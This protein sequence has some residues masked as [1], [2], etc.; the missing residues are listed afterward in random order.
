MTSFQ[1]A[2]IV[3]ELLTAIDK[4]DYLLSTIEGWTTIASQ[5]L[6]KVDATIDTTGSETINANDEA[7]RQANKVVEELKKAETATL[8][9]HIFSL[10]RS[11]REIEGALVDNEAAWLNSYLGRLRQFSAAYEAFFK[12]YRFGDLVRL[13]RVTMTVRDWVESGRVH[14]RLIRDNIA[15]AAAHAGP[16]EGTLTLFFESEFLVSDLAAKLSAIYRI[17]SELCQYLSVAEYQHP[18]R[19]AKI[20]SGS[21]WVSLIG[22]AVVVGLMK[23]LIERTLGYLYRNLTSEGQLKA[24]PKKLDLVEQVLQSAAK[25]EEAGAD[26]D[27][28]RE[29]AQRSAVKISED[30]VTLLGGEP[31]VTVDGMVH[32]FTS[33]LHERLLAARRPKLIEHDGKKGVPETGSPA[34][35]GGP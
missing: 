3:E 19:A 25:L 29:N 17:Y 1:L 32:S 11:L 23:S 33:A 7:R 8:F 27:A 22:S 9:A 5:F 2:A 24:I 20:E 26:V 13:L 15:S 30:L 4:S 28:L 21:L 12:N 34:P 14:L 35:P 31:V 18:L 6:P 16:D 10:E